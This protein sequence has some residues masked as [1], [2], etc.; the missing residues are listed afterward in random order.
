MSWWRRRRR[1]RR[2]GRRRRRSKKAHT[3]CDPEP[4]ANQPAGVPSSCPGPAQAPTPARAARS[5]LYPEAAVR[6]M[7]EQQQQ[8]R[9]DDGG[10]ADRKAKR[11]I[12]LC[13]P[14]PAAN[15]PVGVSSS[16]PGPAQAPTPACAAQKQPGRCAEGQSMTQSR[17]RRSRTERPANTYGQSQLQPMTHGRSRGSCASGGAPLVVLP[18]GHAATIITLQHNAGARFRHKRHVHSRLR[19]VYDILPR[20]CY[21]E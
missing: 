2:R 13:D 20:C 11:R 19:I 12:P 1:R 7:T 3:L 8:Q 10:I 5:K 6:E 16:R 17:L 18:P 14:E 21:L 9:E 4:A 15:Q